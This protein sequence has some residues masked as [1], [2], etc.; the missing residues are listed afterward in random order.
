[1]STPNSQSLRFPKELTI[2]VWLASHASQFGLHDKYKSGDP[3]NPDRLVDP[4][5]YLAAVERLEKACLDQLARE[6]RR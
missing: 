6:Q 4:A 5:G 3:Y 2:D 1:V